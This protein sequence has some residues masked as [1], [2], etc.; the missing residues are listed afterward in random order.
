MPFF[1]N[2]RCTFAFHQW[3]S[4]HLEFIS[5]G[6]L[7]DPLKWVIYTFRHLHIRGREEFESV[8]GSCAGGRTSV[9]PVL[10]TPDPV[11]FTKHTIAFHPAV[12]EIGNFKSTP[13]AQYASKKMSF[14]E[15]ESHSEFQRGP[16][17]S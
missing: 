16:C 6:G 11:V 3:I 5:V 14:R 12:S 1:I 10:L 15:D 8:H 2:A 4:K 9:D 17:P 7:T 13:S